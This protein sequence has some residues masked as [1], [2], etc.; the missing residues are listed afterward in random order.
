MVCEPGHLDLHLDIVVTCGAHALRASIIN[1]LWPKR[2]PTHQDGA[3]LPGS[4]FDSI[5]AASSISLSLPHVR[6][7]GFSM[8]PSPILLTG[9]LSGGRVSLLHFSFACF[10]SFGL[11]LSSSSSQSRNSNIS[12]L[13]A[14]F[15]STILD[16]LGHSQVIPSGLSSIP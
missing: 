2:A 4:L 14:W 9:I 15:S 1:I 3:W 7:A 13:S 6:A 5:A 12:D 16:V 10:M 11:P 8:F